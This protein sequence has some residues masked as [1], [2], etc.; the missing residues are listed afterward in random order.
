MTNQ[1]RWVVYPLWATCQV[2]GYMIVATLGLLLPSISSDLSLSP[3][4]QG[5]LGSAAYWGNMVL[6]LPFALIASQFKPKPLTTITLALGTICL[7][8]QGWAPVFSLLIVGRLAFGISILAREPARAMLIQQWFPA[9][10]SVL[11]NGVS[12]AM[13]GLI[14]GSGLIITPL[15]IEANPDWRIVL[16]IFGIMFSVLTVAWVL[17]GRERMESKQEVG[18]SRA[19]LLFSSLRH[20][21]LWLGG[22]GFIG[23][24]FVWSSFLSFYPTMMQDTYGFSLRWSGSILAISI[25]VGGLSGIFLSYIVMTT[26]KRKT[27]LSGRHE[28]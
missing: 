16:R 17:L 3:S 22:S 11:A 10:Q 14:V 28:A 8:L 1:Y 9:K 4:Q 21:D 23:T 6:T 20:R 18:S 25:M 24:N 7:F 2:S 12:N 19:R 27:I 15:M 26:G 13:F 5:L